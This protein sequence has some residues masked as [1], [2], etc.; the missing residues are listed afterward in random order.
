M[1]NNVANLHGKTKKGNLEMENKDIDFLTN[2]ISS[3]CDY[4]V[5]NNM[6]PNETLETVAKNILELLT[7]CNF[8]KW[9]SD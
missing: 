7:I 3:I 2:T 5:K 9:E 8:N 1:Q 4:A 6:Q